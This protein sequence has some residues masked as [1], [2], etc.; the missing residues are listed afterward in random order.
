[1]NF[2]S[3]MKEIVSK[4]EPLATHTTFGIGGPARWF[5]RPGSID[6]LKEVIKRTRRDNISFNMLGQGANL[7]VND[8]GVD[9]VVIRLDAPDFRK[10]HWGTNGDAGAD[11]PLGKKG[12]KV[13]VVANAGADM[14]RLAREAVRRGLSG[15]EC[16]AG[17]PG[18]VGGIIRMNAG[19]P[20]GQIADVVRDITV[21]D[22]FGELRTLSNDEIGFRYRG[23]GLNG[24]VI[25]RATL[26][27]EPG[28]P[29]KIRERFLA[30]LAHKRK[31]QPLSEDSAGCVFK[32]PPGHSAGELIERAGFKGRGVGGAY[33]SRRHAN[34]IV[35]K[36]GA[37][38]RDVLAL[39]GRTR[40]AVLEQFG[41]G[42][43]L[44]IELWG[45]RSPCNAETSIS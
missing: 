44:E 41:V 35:A 7:L 33:V 19:G 39:V 10:V 5:V 28:D 29:R 40:R 3:D 43:D 11:S 13:V 21:I 25:C 9:G 23:I 18:T 30:V 2:L 37:T 15:L 8:D 27:L 45:Y 38:A 6:D 4:N 34:F 24:E 42:L 16:M 20:L 32:N 14:N 26:E 12:R 17:I 36:E 22:E 31:T 1:M